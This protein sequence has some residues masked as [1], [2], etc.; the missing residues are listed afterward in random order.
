MIFGNPLDYAHRLLANISN[1]IRK[2]YLNS[3]YYDKKISNIENKIL[4]YKPSPHLLSSLIKYQKKKNNI[5]NFLIDN[6]WNNKNINSKDFRKLNNFFW[7]FSLDLKSSKKL[8]QSVI[9]NWIKINYKFNSKTW[10][11]DITAKRIIAWLSNYNLTYEESD[12]EYQA[13]FNLM[14]KKQTNHLIN[15]INKSTLLDDKLIGCAAIILVGLCYKDEKK[16]LPVGLGFLRK[17]SK[18]S[19]DN[20]GFVKSR[21]IKQLIF[22]LKYF[23]LIKE[24][25]KEALI[26]VP[27]E[28]EETI[29]HLGKAYAFLWQNTKVDILFNGN[30]NSNNDEFDNYLKRLG[31]KFK[32]ENRELGGYTIFQNKKISLIMD[33]GH[34]PITKFTQNYQAGALSFEIISNGNKLI[35]NCGFYENENYNL[36]YISKSTATHSTLVLDDHSSCSFQTL[37][38][39]KNFVSQGLKITKKDFIFEKN[40]W[41]IN[42]SHNGYQKKFNTIHERKI[43]FYPDELKFIGTDIIISKKLNYNIK[44]DVR[45]HV[46]PGIKLMKTQDNKTILIELKDEGW[47]FNCNNF[48]I[49]IDNG[50][51][52]GNKNSNIQNQNILISG[53]S[54]SKN[55]IIEWQL[56]KI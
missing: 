47:K 2:I 8:A 10:N 21:N 55:E 31:Y 28:I 49:D 18:F 20:Y 35:S 54:N 3:N 11:F 27:D 45:F 13:K 32:N 39:K 5:N 24:W 17:I 43:E 26:S 19:L 14:I 7:F 44:F 52:F 4:I 12:E 23:I 53:I 41:K 29:Y 46:E 34:T 50:L 40:Y 9:F 48:D 16:Y 51:Y 22:Y 56:T 6:L 37:N 36:N 42:A 33:I 25:F 15:E 38:K 1:Q 30:N